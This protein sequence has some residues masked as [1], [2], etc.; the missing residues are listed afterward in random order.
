[1]LHFGFTML[2]FVACRINGFYW[3]CSNMQAKC[4]DLM[5]CVIHSCGIPHFYAVLKFF[6]NVTNEVD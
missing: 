4:L 3:N 6:Q 1:M 2:H 5:H